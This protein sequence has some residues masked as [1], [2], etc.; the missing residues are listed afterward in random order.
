MPL[1]VNERKIFWKLW[2]NRAF[3][4]LC[5][6]ECDTLA[7]DLN[8]GGDC[9]ATFTAEEIYHFVASIVV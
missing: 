7:S 5:S 4:I 3:K 1:H 6:D 9:L 2:I 8:K